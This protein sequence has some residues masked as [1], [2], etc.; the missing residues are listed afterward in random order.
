[1]AE[2]LCATVLP[3]VGGDLAALFEWVGF[4]GGTPFDVAL[5]ASPEIKVVG[6]QTPL[7]FEDGGVA[8]A[9]A[10]GYGQIWTHL[11]TPTHTAGN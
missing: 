6:G 1:M 11:V 5:L 4:G 10:L 8:V 7:V 2:V 9:N 3:C